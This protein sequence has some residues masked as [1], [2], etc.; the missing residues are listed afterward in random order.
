MADSRTGATMATRIC[1]RCNRTF[2]ISLSGTST[3]SD[4]LWTVEY[5]YDKSL[6]EE[7]QV[8]EMDS[9]VA[10]TEDAAFAGACDRIEKWLRLKPC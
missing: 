7:I 3:G 2:E 9:I 10:S 6:N 4:S 8:P 5:V 1:A